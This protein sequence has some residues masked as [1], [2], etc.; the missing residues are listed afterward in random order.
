MTDGFR[1]STTCVDKDTG[2]LSSSSSSSSSS[3]LK[4]H[5]CPLAAGFRLAGGTVDSAGPASSGSSSF[6]AGSHRPLLLWPLRTLSPARAGDCG[7]VACDR[8]VAVRSS[9]RSWGTS[10]L[11]GHDCLCDRG[12]RNCHGVAG[13]Y[14]GD[15]QIRVCCPSAKNLLSHTNH[16]WKVRCGRQSTRCPAPSQGGGWRLEK[17]QNHWPATP[18]QMA[19]KTLFQKGTSEDQNPRCP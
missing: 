4:R 5:F 1:R 14:W 16:P 15:K 10:I 17:F 11:V 2:F 12:K 8:G 3:T 7:T 18:P 13:R 9:S 19:E 6:L